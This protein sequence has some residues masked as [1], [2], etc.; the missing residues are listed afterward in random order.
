MFRLSEGEIH[1]LWWFIQGSI[2][3][4]HMRHWLRRAWGFCNRHAW[5]F[6]S[7]EAAFRHGYLHGPAVLYED[8][9]ERALKAFDAK[10]PLKLIKM[11]RN[12]RGKGQCPMCELG[13]G[14]NSKGVIR[15]DR[16]EVGRDLREIQAFASLTVQYWERLLCGKCYSNNSPMRCRP[17]LLDDLNSNNYMHLKVQ[18]EQIEYIALHIKRF[19]RS[20]RWEF[21]GSQTT[22]D[23]A[24]LIGAVGWCSGWGGLMEIMKAD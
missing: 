15:P 18:K 7:V 14:P 16:V 4:P 5:G 6:I 12:L 23:M 19:S 22:E 2:M 17:H 8:L 20:F 21:Q 11:E 3:E 9:I 24:S 10:G 13:Y 1:Y